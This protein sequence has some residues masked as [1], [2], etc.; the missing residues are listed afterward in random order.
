MTVFG[1]AHPHWIE[2]LSAVIVRAVHADLTEDQVHAHA[3]EHLA[4]YKRPTFVAFVDAL[5]KHP[6]G[7]IL[8]RDLRQAFADVARSDGDTQ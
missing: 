6:S 7:K 2:A 5:P 4:A 8:K 3:R 1:V